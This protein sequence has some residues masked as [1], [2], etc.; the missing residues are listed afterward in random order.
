M[1]PEFQRNVW[2]EMTPQ[3]LV[4]MPVV[5]LLIYGV[6]FALN[7]YQAGG[8]PS[9]AAYWVALA[10]GALWGT[11][12]TAE[13]VTSE[14]LEGTWDQQRLSSLSP[15]SM[16]WGKLFGAP[17]FVWYGCLPSLLVM[18]LGASA[19]MPVAEALLHAM[20][21]GVMLIFA[22]A[23]G[24]L[25]G[26][27]AAARRADVTNRA[28]LALQ[29]VGLLAL[30]PWIGLSMNG[31]F[32]GWDESV[33]WFGHSF[34]MGPF[35]LG[36]LLVFTAW[37]ILGCYRVMRTELQLRNSPWIWLAFVLFCMV[38]AMGWQEGGIGP[39]RAALQAVNDGGA[40]GRWANATAA[41][42]VLTY[43]MLFAEAKDPVALRR[44]LGLFAAGKPGRGLD[45]LPRWI[46]TLPLVI[47]GAAMVVALAADESARTGVFAVSA[48]LFLL[49][50]AGL[51]MFLN[52]SP[53]RR[54]A[55]AA[56]VVY[57]LVLYLLLPALFE[58]ADV[59]ISSLLVPAPTIHVIVGVLPAALQAGAM[60]FFVVRRWRRYWAG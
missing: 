54:R 6:A 2:L 52:L 16:T 53:R 60:W 8:A 39:G 56:A 26:L 55:D 12:A 31:F 37:A 51:V 28:A 4:A 33:R 29:L 18:T 19:R 57:L 5:L 3:R 25:G 22:Q 15:W 14:V 11:R 35:L 48:L 40:L 13:S 24:L 47:A 30:L 58:A 1:N 10:L 59:P 38:Y 49:R 36:N 45:V 23:M 21:L 42:G 46:C 32:D 41:A 34:E 20:L 44:M 43:L 17:V 27:H 50:D 7:G 9:T